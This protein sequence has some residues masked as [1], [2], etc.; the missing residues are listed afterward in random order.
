M[1]A[2]CVVGWAS[3]ASADCVTLAR[4]VAARL[5]VFCSWLGVVVGSGSGSGYGSDVALLLGLVLM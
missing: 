3:S 4:V 1:G 5:C 2:F